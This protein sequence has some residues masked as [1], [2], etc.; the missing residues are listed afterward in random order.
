[1][2][3]PDPSHRARFGRKGRA[4][5]GPAGAAR[6]VEKRQ[7]SRF[8][9]DFNHPLTI[10]SLFVSVVHATVGIRGAHARAAK[11]PGSAHIGC[12]SRSAK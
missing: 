3:A 4:W 8:K 9:S 5:G 11:H 10:R 12:R 2:A 6:S 7:G 1:M